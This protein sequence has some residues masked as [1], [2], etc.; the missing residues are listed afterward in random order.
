[1]WIGVNLIDGGCKLTQGT[2]DRIVLGLYTGSD[3]G[4]MST[5]DPRTRAG[6]ASA[7]LLGSLLKAGGSEVEAVS[8]EKLYEVAGK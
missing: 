4:A 5:D 8:P 2:L 3:T 7:E 1:M 6:L